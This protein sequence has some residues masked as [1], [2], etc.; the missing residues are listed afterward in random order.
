VWFVL[1]VAFQPSFASAQTNVGVQKFVQSYDPASFGRGLTFTLNFFAGS[2]LQ[3]ACAAT[4]AENVVL[5]DLLPPGVTLVSESRGGGVYNR[6]T[7]TVTWNLGTVNRCAT[8]GNEFQMTVAVS[9][10]IPDGT[11]LTDTLM[12]TTTTPETTTADNTAT[13]N[14]QV[15]FLPLQ[16]FVT[17]FKASCS[18]STSEGPFV[19]SSDSRQSIDGT[20]V[21]CSTSFGDAAAEAETDFFVSPAFP[22]AVP[23]LVG[24]I[25]GPSDRVMIRGIGVR[26]TASG[27]FVGGALDPQGTNADVSGPPETKVSAQLAIFNP[28]PYPVQLRIIRD[29]SGYAAASNNRAV[30]PFP[31]AATAVAAQAIAQPHGGDG[32]TSSVD[33][34]LDLS[35]AGCRRQFEES[36]FVWPVTSGLGDPALDAVAPGFSSRTDQTVAASRCFGGPEV[37]ANSTKPLFL[38]AAGEASGSTTVTFLDSSITLV[39]SGY[40]LFTASTSLEIMRADGSLSA[41]TRVLVVQGNSP[42]DLLITDPNGKQLGF[43]LGNKRVINE[44]FGGQYNGHGAEPQLARILNPVAGDYRIDVL[45]IGDGP[46]TV[47]VQ[48][49]DTDGNV[50]STESMTGVASTG[51]VQAFQASVGNAADTIAPTTTATPSPGPNANGWNKTNVVINLSAVDNPGGSG[52]KAINFSLSGAQGGAGG[53][54]GSNAAVTISAE[55]TTTLTYFATDN[56]GNQEAAKTLT[57]RID[58]TPP[59]ISGLPAPGCTLWPPNHRMVQV[60]MVTASDGLSGLAPG[61]PIITATSS[62]AALQVG[63]GQ[64]DADIVI[65]GTSVQLRAERAGAGTGRV[66]MISASASDIAGN[67]AAATAT[68]TVPHDQRR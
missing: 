52:V 19:Q 46:F 58:K 3:E 35:P 8:F 38:D 54:A 21:A 42:I 64:T 17:D 28:N 65:T 16:V 32:A 31:G 4:D 51:S 57:V 27:G 2:P 26:G 30:P 6:D 59:I 44:I 18:V 37:P 61:S 53:V 47:T 49:L 60:A 20:G 12:I 11:T 10:T 1:L 40:G 33:E 9:P 5:T 48:T 45:G 67:S 63:S 13:A 36:D 66:Y 24:E 29:F 43:D 39:R 50:T 14:F 34:R 23:A 7:N 55:G 68:C 25:R 41:R 15:G 22:G 56:A 62:E